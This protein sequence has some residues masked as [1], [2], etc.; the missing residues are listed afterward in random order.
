MQLL[1]SALVA[2][3]LSGL[4][5]AMAGTEER[6]WSARRIPGGAENRHGLFHHSITPC[7][8]TGAAGWHDGRD[9]RPDGGLPR[10]RGR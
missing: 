8:P 10:S 7:M 1:V 9:F 6:W 2:A 3:V 4:P 5:A